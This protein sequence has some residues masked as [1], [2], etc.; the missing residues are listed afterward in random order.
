MSFAFT[1]D[2]LPFFV[3]LVIF[4]ALVFLTVDKLLFRLFSLILMLGLAVKKKLPFKEPIE[5][6]S[7]RVNG[8]GWGVEI[9][10]KDF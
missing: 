2:F 7:E 6:T 10:P 1:T 9:F 8:K 4:V 5:H 3:P